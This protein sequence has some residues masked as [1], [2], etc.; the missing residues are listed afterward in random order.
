M[1]AKEFI[2]EQREHEFAAD[3]EDYE[4]REIPNA[5]IVPTASNNFYN[6]YR[7]GVLMARSPEQ[8]PDAYDNQTELGDKL[9]ITPYTVADEEIMRGASKVSGHAAVK[10]HRYTTTAEHPDVYKQSP[11]IANSGK[12]KKTN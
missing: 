5:Y 11:I 6:M 1:R 12:S 9:I 7:Y 2:N 8:Q 4:V 10:K 3:H